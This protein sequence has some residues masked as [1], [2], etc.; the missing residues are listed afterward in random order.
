MK[1]HYRKTN[2]FYK[3][4]YLNQSRGQYGG[5]LPGYRGVYFQ[6]GYG[7]GA[8]LKGLFR[9][10]LPIIKSG[11]QTVG[12][13]ALATGINVAKDYADGRDLK[14]ALK[15]RGLEAANTLSSKA[16]NKARSMISQT[17]KGIKRRAPSKS[18]SCSRAKKKKTSTVKAR[19]SNKTRKTTS[20]KLKSKPIKKNKTTKRNQKKKKKKSQK[21]TTTYL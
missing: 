16:V 21:R 17:G 18:V 11:A 15:S 12:K 3:T 7:I 13:T 1:T 10:A 6:R 8:F 2:D 5:A 4:Y 20:R 9:S 19:K 14:T